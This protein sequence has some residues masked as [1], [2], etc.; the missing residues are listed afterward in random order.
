MSLVARSLVAGTSHLCTL[1]HLPLARVDSRYFVT[2][3]LILTSRTCHLDFSTST[4]APVINLYLSRFF[5]PPL[6]LL[7]AGRV[8]TITLRVIEVEKLK[9]GREERGK[10]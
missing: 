2:A 5:P 6:P 7:R 1:F 4:P 8:S 10:A 9:M 3:P